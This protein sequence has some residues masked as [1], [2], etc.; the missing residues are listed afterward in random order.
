MSNIISISF[1]YKGH[2]YH[3]LVRIKNNSIREYHITVMNGQLET[4]LYGNHIF[5]ESNGKFENDNPGN[6]INDE[7]ILKLREA[8]SK[9]LQ[10]EFN[11]TSFKEALLIT[12]N[13]I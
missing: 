12:K 8:I 10:K 11:L 5:I 4:L 7:D 6:K 2:P 1:N 3:A 13:S 9:A